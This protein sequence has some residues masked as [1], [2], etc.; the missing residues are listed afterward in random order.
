MKIYRVEHPG[1]FHRFYNLL[2]P[3]TSNKYFEIWKHLEK[4]PDWNVLEIG[5]GTGLY[6]NLLR[7]DFANFVATDVSHDMLAELNKNY[8]EIKTMQADATNLAQFKDKTFD[9][10]F[11]MSVLHHIDE[12][13]RV[14]ALREM[15]R[16]LKPGG[17]VAVFEPYARHPVPLLFQLIQ[18]EPV[19]TRTYL[20]AMMAQ[21]RFDIQVVKP[22]LLGGVAVMGIGRKG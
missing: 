1:Q 4:D 11:C 3:V 13:Q 2:F 7:Q 9:F 18:G 12:G 21:A 15:R 20:R 10:V 17:Y 14:Q 6:S 16:V 8:P 19:F 22:V 5:C